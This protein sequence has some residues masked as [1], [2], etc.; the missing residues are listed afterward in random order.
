LSTAKNTH[1]PGYLE[2]IVISL[3]M[4][5]MALFCYD[6]IFAQKIKILD[7]KGYLRAQKSLLVTG[8]IT[9]T[10]WKENLDRLEKTINQEAADANSII[11]L[12]EVVLRN[13]NEI[14]VK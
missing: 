9:E 5:A 3:V 10:Q 14:I 4:A 11:L 12:K 1:G 8:E 6:R 13:G 2:V 7:L